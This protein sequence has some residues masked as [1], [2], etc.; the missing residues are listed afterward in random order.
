M[1]TI[2]LDVD[3]QVSSLFTHITSVVLDLLTIKYEVQSG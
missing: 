2:K 1:R 3:E